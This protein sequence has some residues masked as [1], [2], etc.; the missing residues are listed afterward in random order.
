M[1]FLFTFKF[2][3]HILS[4]RSYNEM[5]LSYALKD[6]RQKFTVA[7]KCFVALSLQYGVKC[8]SKAA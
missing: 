2:G 6:S 8:R 5:F 4:H 3:L 7:L 1:I